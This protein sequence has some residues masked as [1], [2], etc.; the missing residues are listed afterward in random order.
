MTAL[1]NEMPAPLD[2]HSWIGTLV[3]AV[4]GAGAGVAAIGFYIRKWLRNDKADAVIHSGYA[5]AFVNLRI[6]V[7][8]LSAEMLVMSVDLGRERAARREAE[9]RAIVAERRFMD[10]TRESAML[11]DRVSALEN[12]R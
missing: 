11:S 4:G 9:E 3:A 10:C 12:G 8:R 6:E 1:T 7:E 5:S 2:D